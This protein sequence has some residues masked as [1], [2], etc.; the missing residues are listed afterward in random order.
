MSESVQTEA[1]EAADPTEPTMW[2]ECDCGTPYVH[3]RALT[4]TGH[5]WVWQADCKHPKK[6][7]HPAVIMTTTGAITPRDMPVRP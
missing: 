1:K 6:E 7:L 4:M 2:P 3:R 5:R